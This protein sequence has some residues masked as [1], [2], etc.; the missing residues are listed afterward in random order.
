MI[1]TL[2]VLAA[3]SLLER[4]WRAALRYS[5][6]TAASLAASLANPYG[7]MGRAAFELMKLTPA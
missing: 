2:G 4:N 5:S 3:G 1:L 6:L 7:F